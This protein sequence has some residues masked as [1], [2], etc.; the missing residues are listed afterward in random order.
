MWN[1]A[2]FQMPG[3]GLDMYPGDHFPRHFHLSC[4]QFDIR[5]LYRRSDEDGV[6]RF[7]VVWRKSKRR[8]WKPLS[9][10]SERILLHQID[11]F[12]DQL[13]TEWERLHE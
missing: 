11:Q 7:T 10:G 8:N 13:E 6:V 12:F 2:G 3:Y 4:S 9:S 5:I 1:I